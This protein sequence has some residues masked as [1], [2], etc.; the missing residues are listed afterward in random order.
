MLI[1]TEYLTTA[2]VA[3]S[4]ASVDPLPKTK[5]SFFLLSVCADELL[6]TL[7]ITAFLA[8]SPFTNE[9]PE[10]ALNPIL[11]PH[12]PYLSGSAFLVDI[13]APNKQSPG[14]KSVFKSPHLICYSETINKF[15]TFL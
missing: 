8:H 12:Y 5:I 7:K 13:A 6:S 9:K 2:V 11:L 4:S 10:R 14:V 1:L 3:P 15:T